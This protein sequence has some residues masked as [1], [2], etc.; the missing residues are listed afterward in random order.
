M[1][2]QRGIRH[3]DKVDQRLCELLLADPRSSNRALAEAIDMTDETVATRLRTLRED[4]VLAT[5]VV[6]DWRKAG[7]SH[8]AV[9]RVRVTGRTF[10]E[11]VRPLVGHPSVLALTEVSGVCDGVVHLLATDA[12]ALQEF[13]TEVL[14]PLDGVVGVDL[15]LAVRELKYPTTKLTLPIPSWD[16]SELPAPA[17]QLDAVDEDLVRE[18]A[19]DGHQSYSELG[20]RLA[21]SDATIRRRVQRLEDSGLFSIVAAIDP[22]A[23]GDVTSIAF[24][25]LDVAGPL[26]ELEKAVADLPAVISATACVGSRDAVLVLGATEGGLT[27]MASVELASL[28]GVVGTD[29]A[30]ANDVIHHR[31]HLVS[32][33]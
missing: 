14:R 18:L 8:Q 9:A 32:L 22:V 21:V 12:E 10:S 24:A 6:V 13:A 16:P 33:G 17:L 23:T 31:S 25:F 20:R 30:Y 2:R 4:G 19:L 28:P 29:V 5:T 3:L 11:V 26:A 15:S 27:R 1:R 7:Y